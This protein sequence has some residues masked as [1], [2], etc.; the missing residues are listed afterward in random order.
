M[1]STFYHYLAIVVCALAVLCM[2]VDAQPSL[3]DLG[4]ICTESEA[5]LDQLVDDIVASLSN[6]DPQPSGPTRRRSLYKRGF[7]AGPAAAVK[8]MFHLIKNPGE[9]VVDA[10]FQTLKQVKDLCTTENPSVKVFRDKLSE[11]TFGH[12]DQVCKCLVDFA[13]SDPN[14]ST[15]PTNDFKS[16]DS[17]PGIGGILLANKD[18][19]KL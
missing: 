16:C 17:L 10:T 2:R 13:D 11:K 4:I 19:F 6:E 7:F 18:K 1:K 12:F 14:S 15:G 9:Q 8:G 3:C 5:E